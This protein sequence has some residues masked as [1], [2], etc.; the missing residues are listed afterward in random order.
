MCKMVI[1]Y[2]GALYPQRAQL[3][4]IYRTSD[5]HALVK[6]VPTSSFDSAFK[7]CWNL[8]KGRWRQCVLFPGR[9]SQV[10]NTGG[11]I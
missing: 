2:N 5:L 6:S 3:S 10:L 7:D 4:I 8:H 11:K 1:L 9:Q